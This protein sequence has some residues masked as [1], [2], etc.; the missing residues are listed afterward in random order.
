MSKTTKIVLHSTALVA[1]LVLLALCSQCSRTNGGAAEAKLS[2]AGERGRV[3]FAAF[4][5]QCHNVHD[6]FQ[7]GAQGPPIA[8]SSLE[9]LR[10]RVL[11]VEYPPG[12]TPKRTT[13]QMVALPH[14]EPYLDDIAVFLAE[15]PEPAK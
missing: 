9:L 13:Q 1:V 15:V 14:V 7:Q 4:C 11:R 6:P 3:A 2:E 5:S 12:Y 10:A 8:R